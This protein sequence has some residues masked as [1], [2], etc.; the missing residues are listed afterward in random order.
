M[1]LCSPATGWAIQSTSMA[2]RRS[3]TKPTW[4]ERA[5]PNFHHVI[6][7]PQDVFQWILFPSGYKHQQASYLQLLGLHQLNSLKFEV[8]IY[9]RYDHYIFIVIWI[10]HLLLFVLIQTVEFL[11]NNYIVGIVGM[12]GAGRVNKQ[13][14]WVRY[15]SMNQTSNSNNEFATKNYHHHFLI[16]EIWLWKPQEK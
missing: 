11:V 4:K 3:S 14:V 16:C 10:W 12:G 15:E 13:H 6:S 5:R 1:G 7:K 2:S 9:N 8:D